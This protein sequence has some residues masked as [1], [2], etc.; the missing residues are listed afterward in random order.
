LKVSVIER[1][2]GNGAHVA[3]GNIRRRIT[4]VGVIDDVERLRTE[5]SGKPL[6]EGK[7]LKGGEVELSGAGTAEAIPG[8]RSLIPG[9]RYNIGSLIKPMGG[10][11]VGNLSTRAARSQVGP[12]RNISAASTRAGTG[13]N[14]ERKSGAK[15]DD[16]LHRRR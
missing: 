9:R 1:R 8:H 7:V 13:R 5:L 6:C 2:S 12:L 14:R 11:A 10:G 15:L 16:G 3:G 4:E